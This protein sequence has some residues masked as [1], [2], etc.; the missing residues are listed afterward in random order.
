M[1]ARPQDA[2]GSWLSELHGVTTCRGEASVVRFISDDYPMEEE[3]NGKVW[4]F[5]TAGWAHTSMQLW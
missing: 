2:R 3:F 1:R 5:D 4:A